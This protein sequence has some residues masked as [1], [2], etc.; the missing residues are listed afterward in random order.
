MASFIVQISLVKSCF[1]SLSTCPSAAAWP[2]PLAALASG[3]RGLTGSAGRITKLSVASR[4][5]ESPG[6]PRGA[7][8]H[9]G[10]PEQR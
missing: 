2:L 4:C 3:A 9:A 8:R 6:A 10:L 1:W 7:E 5:P